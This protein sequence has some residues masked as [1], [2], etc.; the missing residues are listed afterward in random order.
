MY[1]SC[2]ILAPLVGIIDE[3]SISSFH[4]LGPGCAQAVPCNYQKKLPYSGR[5]EECVTWRSIQLL[6][7][8]VDEQNMA[9][10]IIYPLELVV[11]F[12]LGTHLCICSHMY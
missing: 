5:S 12:V 6:G 10:Q 8:G 3:L 7:E 4:K 1:F 2:P 9:V 11:P